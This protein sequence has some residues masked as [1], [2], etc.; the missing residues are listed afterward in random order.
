MES[1]LGFHVLRC[2]AIIEASVLSFEQAKQHIRKLMEQ[3]RKRALSAGAGEAVTGEEIEGRLA[4]N[5]KQ[6]VNFN[7]GEK[8]MR[9]CHIC[10][11]PKVSY[12]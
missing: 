1:E 7:L 5:P 9:C 6:S 10:S 8:L 2:D 4:V 11:Y 12:Q 3:K